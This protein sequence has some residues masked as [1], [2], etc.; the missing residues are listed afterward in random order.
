VVA[1]CGGARPGK[2]LK[3]YPTQ[4]GA[5]PSRRSLTKDWATIVKGY[6][7]LTDDDLNTTLAAA[8]H[9]QVRPSHAVIDFIDQI[10]GKGIG[11]TLTKLMANQLS[12]SD[13]L[14][15]M[16]PIVQGMLANQK[17]G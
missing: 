4:V 8:D 5:L 6:T 7:K 3:V 10:Y 12:A 1:R 15:A 17:G 14:A 11:P 16:T 9:V 13:A 2:G